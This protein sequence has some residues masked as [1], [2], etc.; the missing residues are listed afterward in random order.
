[1]VSLPDDASQIQLAII[2]INRPKPSTVE[3]T[4]TSG[5]TFVTPPLENGSY[6]VAIAFVPKTP[7]ASEPFVEIDIGLLNPRGPT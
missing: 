1:L 5:T 3:A 4:L 7:T 6:K 2:N